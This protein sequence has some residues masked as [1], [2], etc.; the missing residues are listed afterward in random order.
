MQSGLPQDDANQSAFCLY[1]CTPKTFLSLSP[2]SD[3]S[4]GSVGRTETGRN[5]ESVV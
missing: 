3:R 1:Y 4:I 5:L 2:S